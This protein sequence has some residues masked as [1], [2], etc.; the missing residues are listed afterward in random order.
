MIC[1]K[2]ILYITTYYTTYTVNFFNNLRKI[3]D[4]NFTFAYPNLKKNNNVKK[5]L[6]ISLKEKKIFNYLEDKYEICYYKLFGLE[7]LIKKLKPD[8]IVVHNRHILNFVINKKILQL[9]KKIGFK[10]Y[11]RTIPYLIP[12]NKKN[13]IS[14]YKGKNF[15]KRFILNLKI[16]DLIVIKYYKIIFGKI[17]HFLTYV[18]Q[19]KK[20]LD[21]M[22]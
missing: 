16:I 11:Y 19:G 8:I 22:G 10:V 13:L 2:N 17:D 5:R 6:D 20:L 7:N 14:H 12:D 18:P 15:L 3:K 1:V 4:I 9:K 21:L